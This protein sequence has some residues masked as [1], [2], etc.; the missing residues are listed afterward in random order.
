MRAV[1]RR[2]SVFSA[3][4]VIAVL[5]APLLAQSG[6]PKRDPVEHDLGSDHFI[7][8]SSVSI[9]TP[10][11]GDL[12]AAGGNVDV[13]A[14]IGG[15]A[16]VAGGNVRLG[17]AVRHG[18]Y[19]AG[20]RVALNAPVQ[21]NARMA[22]GTIEIGPQARI[23]GNV[24]AGAGEVRISGPID[25]YLQVGAG[26][27]VIDA[28]VGGNVEVASE[29]LELGP[30]ARISGRLRYV[31][32]NE[33]QR[34]PAAE[35]TG[36]IERVTPS[37]TWPVPSRVQERAGRG[38]GWVWS[39]G[40]MLIAGILAVALPG[41]Y[42]GVGATMQA[43]WALSLLVGF[44]ALVCIPV[45]AVIAMFTVIGVPLGLAA[46]AL[47]LVLLLAGYVST[48]VVAG[49][50]ALTRLRAVRASH[51]GWRFGAAALGMFSISLLG[52]L[53]WVGG[54]IV[55]AALLVGIGALLMQLRGQAQIPQGA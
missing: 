31:S 40:L 47:Y 39:A 2:V 44:I 36:G 28:P 10:V 18:V 26:R 6:A 17:A 38:A 35:V 54:L 13:S 46:L 32:R 34:D 55:L 9:A 11:Q 5:S 15:D 49:G 45:A 42:T 30:K 23:G 16:V 24:S 20:G 29:V 50:L 4:M 37:A 7:A 12:V 14:E 22:G 52:R 27:V 41:V 51:P 1:S 48:G 21:R 53:P 25:G 43:R 33:V 19:A 8:G 3:V